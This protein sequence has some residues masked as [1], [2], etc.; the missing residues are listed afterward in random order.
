MKLYRSSHGNHF[1]NKSLQKEAI[2]ILICIRQGFSKT[3]LDPLREETYKGYPL[4]TFDGKHY[5][6]G[7]SEHFP[8]YIILIRKKN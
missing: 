6:R 4:R 8:V 1:Y 7:Y 2:L 3:L 5:P